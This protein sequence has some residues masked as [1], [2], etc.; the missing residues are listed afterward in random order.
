M[1]VSSIALSGLNQAQTSL[2][3]TARRISGAAGQGDSVDFSTD[4]V[5][6]L[7]AK[8]DFETNIQVL[9]VASEME[10]SAINLVA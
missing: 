7:Q 4:A 3:N 9:K 10:K 6:L 2:E 1:D 5:N 8:N